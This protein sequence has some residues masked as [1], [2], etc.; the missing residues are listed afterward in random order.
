MEKK[1]MKTEIIY[2]TCM[3]DDGRYRQPYKTNSL[4][5]YQKGLKKF[6]NCFTAYVD[7]DEA[8]EYVRELVD[9]GNEVLS[10][11]DM[12]ISQIQLKGKQM[13]IQKMSPYRGQ[14]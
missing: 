2:S 10:R 4:E 14:A 6:D 7:V 8:D 12:T 1:D 13:L 3:G 9:E 11:I 5:E